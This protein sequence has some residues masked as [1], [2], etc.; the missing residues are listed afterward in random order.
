MPDEFQ[1]T[2]E[3]DLIGSSS[4]LHGFT[5][6]DQ[7]HPAIQNIKEG[8]LPLDTWIAN[9]CPEDSDGELAFLFDY[10]NKLIALENQ[11]PLRNSMIGS[12]SWSGKSRRTIGDT[13]TATRL[14]GE[15]I[16]S[17]LPD[18]VPLKFLPIQTK[19]FE[20]VDQNWI[21]EN[22]LA[23]FAYKFNEILVVAQ[24]NGIKTVGELRNAEDYAKVFPKREKSLEKT[25]DFVKIAFSQKINSS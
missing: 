21:R 11:V 19:E 15:N 10:R 23:N 16:G 3:T 4:S 6:P 13:P 14:Y 20:P 7:T 5:R 1:N 9:G 24:R 25:V 8:N 12:G 17:N 2:S 22:R 18:V